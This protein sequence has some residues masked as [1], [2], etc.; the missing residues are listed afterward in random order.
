MRM[1]LFGTHVDWAAMANQFDRKFE[2]WVA[3]FGHS[4]SEVPVLYT[5]LNDLPTLGTAKAVTSV[6]DACYI[7]T[8]S[9]VNV[10]RIQ[11]YSGTVVYATDQLMNPDS[12]VFQP[13]GLLDSRGY[14]LRGEISAGTASS[15]SR[16]LFGRLKAAVRATFTSR[17][18]YWVGSDAWRVYQQG[19]R[20]TDDATTRI[21]DVKLSV[22]HS[23]LPGGSL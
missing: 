14:I 20:F 21:N 9:P 11:Q 22:E 18:G 13:G 12:V 5:R 15:A 3:V 10:R 7:V 2:G 17:N 4:P 1:L 23:P 8:D 16:L 19:F 6:Q